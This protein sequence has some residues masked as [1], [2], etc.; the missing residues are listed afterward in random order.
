MPLALGIVVSIAIA[1]YAELAYRRLEQAN[2]E[3][4][5]ALEMQATLHATLAQI[6]S[7]EGGQRGYLLTGRREYLEPYEAAVPAIGQSISAL[8]ELLVKLGT[9]GTARDHRSLQQPGR[10]EARRDGGDARS[11]R[12]AG[13]WRGPDADGN[14]HRPAR[15]D[16]NPR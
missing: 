11:L 2:R 4:S 8:R 7:A 6:V 10:E 1:A 3:M 16:G 13:G 9:R 12:E 14:G 5:V 15:D